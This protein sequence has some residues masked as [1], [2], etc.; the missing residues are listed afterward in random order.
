MMTKE[1]ADVLRKAG[2]I[3]KDPENRTTEVLAKSEEGLVVNPKSPH[4]CKFCL[5]GAIFHCLPD[6]YP[7]P[8]RPQTVFS[9]PITMEDEDRIARF[10]YGHS[11]ICLATAW[12]TADT[13]EQDRI[14]N[15]L[16]NVRYLEANG[17]SSV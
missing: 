7:H 2:E 3:L 4:A 11:D 6:Y 9:W 14:V 10:L 12:D 13:E 1:L 17:S 16:L 8:G 15:A 5:F